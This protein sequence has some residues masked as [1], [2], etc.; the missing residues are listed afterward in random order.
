MTG[1]ITDATGALIP[2][3]TVTLMD[4]ATNTKRTTISNKAGQY[5]MVDV[6]PA[7]YNISATKSGFSTDEIAGQVVSVGTQTTANFRMMVGAENT[8]IEVQASA[9]DL[10]TL[11][12]TVG[13]TVSPLSI[14][15]L[16]SVQRDVST[17]ASLQP[18]VTPGGSDAGTLT[19][20][21]VFT[22]DG[23][24]NSSDMD[25]SM[26]NYTG[27]FA[28][29][30]TGVTALGGSSSGVMPTPQDSIEEFRVATSGQTAD[31]NNS[32]GLQAQIVTKRGRNTVHGTAYEY[33]LDSN[34]G[35]NTWQNRIPVTT[36]VNG[37]PKTTTTPKPSNHYNRFGGSLGGPVAPAFLGGRTYLFGNY[38]GFR[39]PNSAT[40]ERPVPSA[41]LKNGFVTLNVTVN[42]VPTPT[43]FDLH[44]LDPRGIGIS[45]IVQ[46]MWNTEEPAGNDP[47]CTGISGP[48]CDGVNEIG[49][50]ATL[51]IPQK[52]DFGVVRLDHDFGNKW[53][54]NTSFRQ[55]AFTN[56]TSNQVD[57]GGVLG[58]KLGTP[59]ALAPRP[60]TPWYLVAGLTTNITSNFTN[61]FHYSYLRNIW[62]WNS[63]EA[64]A[65]IPGLG[66]ALEP[67]GEQATQVLS[68]YKRQHA[69]DPG[70][71][72]G[73]TRPLLRRRPHADSRKPSHPVRRP[74]P[75]QFRVP[76]PH[77]QW[78]R[79]QLHH[80]LPTR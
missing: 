22:L 5:V 34:I 70:T 69:A 13:V 47:G 66:G 40:F 32:T 63:A 1:T 51:A 78:W 42:G 39:Y 35:A 67:L 54:F 48:R 44:A 55:Y 68:P 29:N 74:V 58:G 46:Q 23:G 75:T 60:Q 12:A 56:L 50:R 10:Q 38:E 3:A 9:A 52:S 15:S 26:I 33:Y 19:D 18:G 25:G 71:R 2:G 65:Q 62:Y 28:G 27:S 31:F 24:N 45:P 72:L 30:P 76:Q 6:P 11:N 41:D 43:R 17:F 79:H 20:Q 80:H 14:E 37:V 16:P 4:P 73:R 8:T 49:Y 77:G 64:P 59:T 7:T 57:I 36:I 61:E 21:A 53:H